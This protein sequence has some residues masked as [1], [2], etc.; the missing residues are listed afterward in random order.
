VPVTEV[1]LV[2]RPRQN[3]IGELAAFPAQKLLWFLPVA[4][5][6]FL[7]GITMAL[8]RFT[9]PSGDDYCRAACPIGTIPGKVALVYRYW[10]GRWG[11]ES[12]DM[13]IFPLHSF[14]RVYPLFLAGL[15]VVFFAALCWF[16]SSLVGKTVRA[17]SCAGVAAILLAMFLAGMPN[18]Q[19][20]VFWVTGAISSVLPVFGTACILGLLFSA[21]A[22]PKL[23]RYVCLVLACFCVTGLHELFAVVLCITLG[24][25]TIATILTR[26]PRRW[27][28]TVALLAATAGTAIVILAPGNKARALSQFAGIPP[29]TWKQIVVAGVSNFG[30][31]VLPWF[32]D[33][34]LLAATLLLA[35]HPAIRKLRP[36]WVCRHKWPLGLACLAGWL[37]NTTFPLFLPQ[38]VNSQ[39]FVLPPRT[40]DGV[41]ATFLL[42]WFGTA[43][44]FT[45]PAAAGERENHIGRLTL[46]MVSLM[47]AISLLEAPNSLMMMRDLRLNAA[48]WNAAVVKRMNIIERAQA[49]NRPGV[50]VPKLPEAP[51]SLFYIEAVPDPKA[52]PNVCFESYFGLKTFAVY[53]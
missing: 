14:P 25:G 34:K 50:V 2:Y 30:L 36:A 39:A 13:A 29:A 35:W 10:A 46:A 41:Y 27:F 20:T 8:A 11:E 53:Y 7:F 40:M 3:W 47:L 18:L 1:Q 33:V 31:H 22:I 6:L 16:V 48:S 15:L 17:G 28:W 9:A 23:V 42:G 45:R 21:R 52:W 19:E 38:L 26:H 5:S 49:E 4:A 24:I 43:F 51:P 37:L 12:L 32:F 44:V